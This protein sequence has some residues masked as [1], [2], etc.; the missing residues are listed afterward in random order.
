MS[1]TRKPKPKKKRAKAGRPPI[2]VSEDDI[3]QIE[4]RA[5]HGVPEERIAHILGMSPR[6]FRDKKAKDE[7]ISAALEK[8]QTVADAAMS[9]TLYNAAMGKRIHV[10]CTGCG[11]IV[12]HV[13]APNMTA[14]IWWEKTR[15]G[16][17]ETN[18][19]EH[20][21]D[22]TSSPSFTLTLGRD[23]EHD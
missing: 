12:D 4:A 13:Q 11:Q 22:P 9:Q 20:A 19:Q 7:R 21:I 15:M 18:R 3:R 8:G 6:T 23:V 17:K 16:R 1:S 2:K 14:L 10:A 5:G